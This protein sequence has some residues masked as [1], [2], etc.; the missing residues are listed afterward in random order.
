[1]GRAAIVVASAFDLA[2]N[3]EHLHG[4]AR[5]HARELDGRAHVA[6]RDLGEDEVELWRVRV[7]QLVINAVEHA[8][9]AERVRQ[10]EQSAMKKLRV[11]MADA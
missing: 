10:L 6:L 3:A 8:L 4:A 1:M 9:S 11:L 5:V 7:A 2:G